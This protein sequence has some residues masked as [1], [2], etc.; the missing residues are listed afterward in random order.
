MNSVPGAV[1]TGIKR[2]T[3]EGKEDTEVLGEVLGLHLAVPFNW[4]FRT[5]A[6]LN[7]VRAADA[8]FVAPH[9]PKAQCGVT[10]EILVLAA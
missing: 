2:L 7:K 5:F 4:E 6:A 1:A 3:T 8:I 9:K 10:R